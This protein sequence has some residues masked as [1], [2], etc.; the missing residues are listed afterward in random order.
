MKRNIALQVVLFV[1]ILYGCTTVV[2]YIPYIGASYE[3]YTV[4]KGAEATKYYS[5][6]LQTVHDAVKRSCDQM[7]LGTTTLSASAEYGY[8]LETKGNKPLRVSVLPVEKNITK[9]VVDIGV[10]GDKEYAELFYRTIEENL[11][12]NATKNK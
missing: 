4:W 6:D 7:K 2:T 10:L 8:T 1:L 3:G 11:P 12:K 9:V 5:A